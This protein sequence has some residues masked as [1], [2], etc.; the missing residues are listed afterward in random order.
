M[1]LAHRQQE[2]HGFASGFAA[3]VNFGAETA[4]TI[5]KSLLLGL[6]TPSASGVLMRPNDTAINKMQRSAELA[7]GIRSLLQLLQN[8]LPQSAFAPSIKSTR[9][10]FPR[11][12]AVG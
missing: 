1:T 8:V 10:G 5:P 9:Y 2:G 7:S 6:T 11:P 4:L 12:I 3:E